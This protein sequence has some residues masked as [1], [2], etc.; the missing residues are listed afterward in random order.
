MANPASLITRIVV[1]KGVGFAFGL[2]GLIV[3]PYVAGL[4][5]WRLRLGVLFWYTTMGALVALAGVFAR[6]PILKLEFPWWFR[7]PALGGW[8][9]FVLSLIAYDTLE[10]VM[11][12]VFGAGGL[13]ESP[14]W[15]VLEGAMIGLII[16]LCATK[17][18]GEGAATV[19]Q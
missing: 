12:G 13:L 6:H 2:A 14:Y 19:N 8:M 7:G 3:L 5:D 9:N 18:G 15:I 1:G 16:D 4:T 17:M 11:I 10:A